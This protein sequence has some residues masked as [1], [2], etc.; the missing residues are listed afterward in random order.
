MSLTADNTR[1]RRNSRSNKV[2]F[3]AKDPRCNLGR[4]QR[5]QLEGAFGP[6]MDSF[7]I[8]GCMSRKGL[9][10]LALLDLGKVKSGLVVGLA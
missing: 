1:V 7:Y 3:D 9:G 5:T 6:L 8:K 2:P 4:F 10:V